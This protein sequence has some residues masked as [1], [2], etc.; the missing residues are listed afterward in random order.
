MREKREE[1]Q[2]FNLGG[3]ILNNQK[4]Q[5]EMRESVGEENSREVIWEKFL[6]LGNRV[7][8]IERV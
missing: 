5:K 4:F 1:N 8:Y 6:E 3:L 2:R 7:I